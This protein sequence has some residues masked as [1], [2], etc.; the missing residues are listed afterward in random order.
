MPREWVTFNVWG[1]IAIR[2]AGGFHYFISLINDCSQYINVKF[3]RGKA[4]VFG[5]VT[6]HIAKVEKHFGREAKFLRMDNR[7][8]YI[9]EHMVK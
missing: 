2:S 4:K 3:R 9:N 5:V 6:S 1:P 8:K 7:K